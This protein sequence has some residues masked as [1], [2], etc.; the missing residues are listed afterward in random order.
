[1]E[2]AYPGNRSTRLPVITGC[3]P[4]FRFSVATDATYAGPAKSLSSVGTSAVCSA[5]SALTSACFSPRRRSS[6]VRPITRKI[7]NPRNGTIRINSNHA[8][9]LEGRLF[10]GTTPSAISL[11][12]R[13]AR[14][15]AVA[16]HG[17]MAA[18]LPRPRP[19]VLTHCV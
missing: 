6:L 16:I 3:A 19:T 14:Y 13:S 5:T 15:R 7:A 12:A 9:P 2:S 8:M 11:I 17:A 4:R 18:T 1:M 10:L